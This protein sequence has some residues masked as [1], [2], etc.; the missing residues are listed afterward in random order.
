MGK[1][2]DD[3]ALIHHGLRC[4]WRCNRGDA[5]ASIFLAAGIGVFA[6]SLCY[7]KITPAA[8]HRGESGER[9][10][11]GDEAL[12]CNPK[13]ELSQSWRV[14]ASPAERSRRHPCMAP[15]YARRAR[16]LSPSN[17]QQGERAA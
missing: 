4:S 10:G 8:L 2:V 9:R 16:C 12:G 5:Q 7:A 15:S 14:I 13:F 11:K 3:R 6:A 1:F 17:R